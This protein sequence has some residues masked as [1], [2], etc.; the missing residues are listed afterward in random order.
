MARKVLITG[1]TRGIGKAVALRFARDKADLFLGFFQNRTAAEAT[2]C[3]AR[4]LGAKVALH[5][6]DLKDEKQILGMFDQVKKALGGLDVLVH[7]AAS[8]VLRPASEITAKHWDWAMNTNARSFLTCATEGASV[9]G[10]GGRIVAG[11]G[12]IAT[13]VWIH[14]CGLRCIG[15]RPPLEFV[16][17]DEVDPRTIQIGSHIRCA[18]ARRLTCLCHSISHQK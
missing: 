6:I 2:E 5:Q 7:C 1:G 16:D 12:G 3:E 10:E 18:V 4:S 13:L 17:A 14:L 9:M 8:G 11:S 15:A